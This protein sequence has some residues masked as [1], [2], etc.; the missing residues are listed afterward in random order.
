MAFFFW[1]LSS[2]TLGHLEILGPIGVKMK[3]EMIKV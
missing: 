3:Q 1:Y 2:G